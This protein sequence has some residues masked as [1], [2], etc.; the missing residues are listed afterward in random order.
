LPRE[1]VPIARRGLTGVSAH[2]PAGMRYRLHR[3]VSL[4]SREMG[5]I[6]QGYPAWIARY[7]RMDD[8]ARRAILARIAR[9]P[10]HPLISV[11]MPVYNPAPAA[12]RTAIHSVQDQFYPWWELCIA[13]DASTDPAVVEV[14]RQ[15]QAG[16]H[17]IRLT[18]RERNGHISVAS[19]TALGLATGTFV[20]LLDHDDILPPHALYE[21][22][23]RI[24]ARPDADL[25]YSDEDHVSAGGQRQH[26]YFKPDWDP[27]LALGQNL[28]SHLGV[29]RRSLVEQVGG[30]R[31]G[32]EG[33]QDHDLALRVAAASRPDRII[34]IPRVLYHWRQGAAAQTFSEAAHDRCVLNA[35]RAIQEQ[36]G[37]GSDAVPA[38]R[39]PVWTRVIHALPEPAPLVSVVIDAHGDAE[40]LSGCLDGLTRLTDYPAIEMIVAGAAGGRVPD[41]PR[42]RIRESDSVN[43][44]AAAAQGALLLLFDA[45]LV[46]AEAGWLRELASQAA[47]PEIGAVGAKL[48]TR[49]GLVRHAGIVVGG[50]DIAHF[51]FAGRRAAETGYFGHLQLVRSVSAVSTASLMVRRQD[52]LAVGGLDEAELTRPL[53]DVDLCLK[54][55]RLG[56][57]NIW[58]PYAQLHQTDDGQVPRDSE[59][60]QRERMLMRQRWGGQLDRDRYWSP[61]LSLEAGEIK[62]AF[63]PREPREV[64]AA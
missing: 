53:Q 19:N 57:R 9:M 6:E 37:S 47:R 60:I 32:F 49:H 34:H 44:A 15:A 20:A 5:A 63:P 24:L 1:W 42:V 54:L 23:A 41:N 38:P 28:V 33:S 31:E 26:P 17:R 61:N 14:L 3:L 36:V 39:V 46:P 10:Q 59:T 4:I 12:L 58:T 27:E 48:L 62:L 51:P 29:Y 56:R 52:F 55:M 43:E 16:D 30:F 50:Q 8:A 25:L 7:D 18:R 11:L 35:R 2:L 40:R 13:D 21:V 45:G 64:E 22:A